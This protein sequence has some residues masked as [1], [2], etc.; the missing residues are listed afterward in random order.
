MVENRFE[1]GKAQLKRMNGG[2]IDATLNKL[3]EI[4]PDLCRYTVEF[5]YGDILCR[6]GL[7]LRSRE[8][9][10]VAALTVLGNAP[11]QLNAHIS[12]ALNSGCT[13]EEIT[14]VI[15]QMAIYAGF[16]AAWNGMGVAKEVF[17]KRE[18]VGMT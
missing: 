12:M 11:N 8:I 7:D 6:P 1:R 10:T 14:E 4:S 15:I 18:R 3:M 5:P 2:E 16:P 17:D 13:K 9:A